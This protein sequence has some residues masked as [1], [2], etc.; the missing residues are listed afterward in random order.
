MYESQNIEFKQSWHDEYLKWI[1]G[2]ANASGGKMYIGIDDNGNVTGLADWKKMMEDIPNKIVNYL[3]IVVQVNLLEKKSKEYIEII[4]EP[5]SVPISYRGTHYYRSGSTKQ[6]LKGNALHQFL[7]KRLGRTW[8]DF[9]CENANLH[10]IDP[11]AINYFFKKAVISKRIAPYSGNDDLATVLE[12]LDLF[13]DNGKLKN[14]ALLL[15]GKRPSRFFPSVSFKIGRFIEGD[16]DLRFQDV[17]DGNIL[18]M[19]DKVMDV[20]KSKYLISP[21]HYEGLQRIERLEV[22]EEALREAIFNS[23]IHKDYTGAPI[24]LS[25]YNDKLI[26]WNEGR[27]PDDFSIETLLGKHPSRPANKNIADIFFK[28]G[29]IEA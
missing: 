9:P 16:D 12:N 1:S 14:A 7:M 21:I 5:S 4:V 28:A 17:V 22:P 29:F 19:A 20:L 10:D 15:F 23:I 27:L 26:L 25:V 3:G 18:Q 13:T 2:F 11:E 24:Q 8:D 6:E